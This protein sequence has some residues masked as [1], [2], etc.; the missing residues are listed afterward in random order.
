MREKC[1]NTEFFWSVFSHIW[2]ECVDLRSKSSYSVQIREN[3]DQKNSLFGHFLHSEDNMQL[4]FHANLFYLEGLFLFED[5]VSIL[6]FWT[7]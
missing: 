4:L 5:F 2:T 7:V 3:T 6:K 1:S